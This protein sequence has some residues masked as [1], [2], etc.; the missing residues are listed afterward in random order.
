M[1]HVSANSDNITEV[2]LTLNVLGRELRLRAGVPT[3]AVPATEM[4]GVWRMLDKV[5][6]QC[7]A[8]AVRNSGQSVSCGD[9]CGHCCRKLI[10][11]SAT[12]A[13][14]LDAMLEKLSP[15]TRKRVEGRFGTAEARMRSLGMG[16]LI[17]DP[18]ALP[19]E[20]FVELGRSCF[21]EGIECP[22]LEDESCL[23]YEERP[24]S[25]REYLV[26]SPPSHCARD[27]A[28]SS[29][30]VVV[31]PYSVALAVAQLHPSLG[32][33]RNTNVWIPLVAARTWAAAHPLPHPLP[34]VE[35]LKRLTGL[36]QQQGR[37]QA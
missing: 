18:F 14:S 30:N 31:L 37:G 34:G 10:P 16:M 23:V 9:R 1:N 8:E 5:M 11:A 17:D 15:E 2:S 24:L 3:P 29:V 27:A 36:L 26:T 6:A 32:A 35:W 33:A 21:A 4:L 25:C 12:E 20:V 13:W 28:S 7:A 19:R 22:F